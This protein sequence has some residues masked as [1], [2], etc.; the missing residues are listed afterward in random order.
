MAIHCERAADETDDVHKLAEWEL[1]DAADCDGFIV[2]VGADK[3]DSER[4][5][6][7]V[8][9][10]AM[11]FADSQY[12]T[13]IVDPAAVTVMAGAVTVVAGMVTVA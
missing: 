9:P 12:D 3:L 7:E 13:V 1:E 2:V 5:V 10:S 4:W 11:V 8:L 6:D